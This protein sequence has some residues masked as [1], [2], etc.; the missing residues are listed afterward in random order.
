MRVGPYEVT[1]KLGEGGMGEVYRATDTKLKREVAIKVL[2][3]AFTEDKERLARFEREA[4]LLA[5]LHHPNIASIFGLEESAGTKA[6]VMELVEG[7]TLA[8]RLEAGALSLTESFS[9]ALQIAQALEEAHEKGIVHRDLKPQNIKASSEGKIKVLDFGLAKAMDATPGSASAADLARSPTIM[10]SPTLTAVHGT[11]LGM[12]LGTAAYMAPEQA[13][14]VAVDR[15]ADIWAFGVVCFEMLTGRRLFEGETVSD[16]LAAVLRQ[17]IDWSALPPSTPASIRTLLRRC[18]ERNPKNRL[19][20]I[21][22]ARIVI[23]EVSSGRAEAPAAGASPAALA[24][25]PRRRRVWAVA[26]AALAIGAAA[27]WLLHGSPAPPAPASRWT[28][29]LP[30]GYALSTV[31]SPQ[32]ALSRDGGLQAIVVVGASRVAQILVRRSDS[33][34]PQVLSG[35]EGASSPF[36]SPDASWIGFFRDDALMKIPVGG[37]PAIRLAAIK[38]QERGATWSLDGWIYFSPGF[39]EPLSR[40]G[41]GGGAVEPVTHLD[42]KRSERT[43]RWPEALPGGEA[44]I[45]TCDTAAS[46]EYYDDA[47]IEAVRPA[48][49]ERKVLLEGASQARFAP[50]GYLVFARGGSLFAVAF[51]TRKLEVRGAPVEV[52]RSVATNVGSG[53]AQFAIAQSGA[54]LWAPG[55]LSA[56]Y[57]VVS[58]DRQG[59]ER[60]I[61]VPQ[62]PYNE[63]ALSPDGSRLALVGGPGGISD[64]W[65]ADLSRGSLTRLT[66]GDFVHMPTWTPDGSR[67]A[68]AVVRQGSAEERTRVDWRPADGS[69]QA[70][71][72]VAEG[73][74]Q[75]PSSFTPDGSTLIYDAF[76]DAQ[77]SSSNIWAL[78]LGGERHARALTAGPFA[79][80]SGAVSP[81]GRWLAYVSGESGGN[82]V[83]VR[84]FPEGDGRWQISTPVGEEP[85]WGVDGRELFF[86]ANSVLER[87]SIDTRPG[88]HA[89]RQE[90]LLDRV[91]SGGETQ[92]Y[93]LSP[94]G[95]RIFTLRTAAGSGART[96]FDLDLGFARRLDAPLSDR[97]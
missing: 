94:D 93:S 31:D 21:A 19:H 44:V 64:L 48:T 30:E 41:Q 20:D 24:A 83:Y 17:E 35:T 6:L 40:V 49:G 50:G 45:F 68:Y 85:R 69:R 90:P 3:A 25:A 10:N 2:P 78:P 38:N 91:A 81:D 97:R 28:L 62:A 13:R 39:G 9:A 43:H 89:G 72:L 61:E 54:A 51:D 84:P 15:R 80:N 12:I 88:F 16:T 57:R 18:L 7:P 34:E 70:E 46:T 58:V 4:Q 92:S 37:G 33:F 75:Y 47:R 36:F 73:P 14:G 87:V 71:T 32:I 22:D 95:S 65:V 59:N 1:A 82:N 76:D 8:E 5:Q 23:D 63:L 86:R 79:K 29:A 11:Q 96:T 67:L 77:G 53:A 52:V 55:G 42:T 60:P 27:G 26:A 66:S 74:G 56:A